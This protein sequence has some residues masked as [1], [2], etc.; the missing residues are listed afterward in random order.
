MGSV[1]TLLILI[2]L[3]FSHSSQALAQPE[4]FKG[5]VAKPKI[6][7]LYSPILQPAA[8]GRFP[9]KAKLQQLDS[10]DFIGPRPSHPF[11]LGNFS[12]D[13]EWGVVNGYLQVISGK[14]AALQIA[15]ADEFRLEGIMEMANFGGWFLLLGWEEGRGFAVHNVTMKESGSPWF[16]TEFRGGKAIEDR[17]Q[18]FGK[19]EWKGEMPFRVTVVNERLTFE[20][21]RYKLFNEQLIEGY[22]PGQIILG[23]Y[24]TRYGPRPLRVKTLK[25]QGMK[26]SD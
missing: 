2:G 10:L 25:I 21:G 8:Q 6:E 14:N 18:E 22:T 13:G 3:L 12:S 4:G 24:D 19:Y 15:W 20:I 7:T 11:V 9:K 16:I 26:T 1:F 5:V 23:T 17:T